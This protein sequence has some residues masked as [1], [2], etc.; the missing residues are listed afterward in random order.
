MYEI[1]EDFLK[2]VSNMELN[3]A[4]VLVSYPN[5]NQA[6]YLSK[7]GFS[8]TLSE[9]HTPIPQAILKKNNHLFYRQIKFFSTMLFTRSPPHMVESGKELFLI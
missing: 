7:T 2:A 4:L 6:L 8:P 3:T 9:N 1:N 5:H